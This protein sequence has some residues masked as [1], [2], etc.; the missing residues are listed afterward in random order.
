[1]LT[2][3]HCRCSFAGTQSQVNHAKYE[4]SVV[5]CSRICRRSAMRNLY[6]KPATNQGPCPTC[7]KDF[8]SKTNKIYCTLDCY[9]K[10]S[11]SDVRRILH[12]EASLAQRT[13]TVQRCVECSVEFYKKPSRSKP[14][15]SKPCGRSYNAKRFDRWVANPEQMALPQCYDEFLDQQEL[16]CLVA[17]C[18]WRGQHLSI[19]MNAVHGVPADEFKRAAG[20]NLS[21]GIV[22]KP[23]AQT[24]SERENVGV[25]LQP[26]ARYRLPVNT[27]GMVMYRSREADE[28]G[29][30]ARAIMSTGPTR[31]CVGC[32]SKFLQ[33]TQYGRALYCS[34]SCREETYKDRRSTNGRVS[35]T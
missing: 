5:Y 32:G 35:W 3:G 20:F 7:G 10:R 34:V 25:G 23:L 17:G 29:R 18:Q 11:R 1:M 24:L 22:S 16:S 31:T 6:N 33:S 9:L 19:H 30:K 21:S 4:C 2:C 26:H 8:F 27:K 15:C 14:W 13:G 12:I 28:H